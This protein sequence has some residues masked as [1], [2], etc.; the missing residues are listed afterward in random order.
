MT[1]HFHGDKAIGE[2]VE[3]ELLNL[4]K[5]TMKNLH[6]I[7][8]VKPVCEGGY[9]YDLRMTLRDDDGRSTD[10]NIEVKA[11]AGRKIVQWGDR[12]ISE[13]L[14]TGA[15]EVWAD[16]YKHKRPEF[17]HDDV[18]VIVFKNRARGKFY[19]YRAQPVIE[20]LKNWKG[21]LTV[22]DNNCEDTGGW[23]MKFYW[24]PNEDVHPRFRDES[25]FLPGFMFEMNGIVED[26]IREEEL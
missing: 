22:A 14:P 24:S 16:D 19:F 6:Y 5:K 26:E 13:H 12:K 7:E 23:M 8:K 25:M 4:L 10:I 18:H 17:Y 2:K 21:H 9:P 15:I 20:Y 3:L 11:L 1:R